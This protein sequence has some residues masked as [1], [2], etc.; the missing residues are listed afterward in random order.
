MDTYEK[1]FANF[2]RLCQETKNSGVNLVT[3]NHPETLGDT[4]Q[5]LVESLN[6][7]GESGLFL[8]IVPP[9]ERGNDAA[10]RHSLKLVK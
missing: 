6:R 5:E 7:L 10:K 3:I 9:T 1:K 8:A 2:I 4:Y